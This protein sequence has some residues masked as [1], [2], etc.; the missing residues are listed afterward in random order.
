MNDEQLAERY[1]GQYG[2]EAAHPLTV[3]AFV[4]C[5]TQEA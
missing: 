3:K 4:E 1:P 5:R 2:S